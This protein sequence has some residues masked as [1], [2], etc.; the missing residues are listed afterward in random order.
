M[1]IIDISNKRFGSLTAI[2]P[3]DKRSKWD[4]V[5]WVCKCDCGTELYVPYHSLTKGNTKSCGCSRRS[6]RP[7]RRKPNRGTRLYRIWANMKNRCLNKK[8][9]YKYSRYGGRGIAICEEW[10]DFDAFCE[11]ALSSGYAEDLT[12][13]RLNNDGNYCPANCRWVPM[14]IQSKNR[15]STHW[16]TINGVTKCVKDWKTELHKSYYDIIKMEDKNDTLEGND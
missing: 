4:G 16:V 8:D 11:W 13:D 6:P 14:S 2:R 1:K 7:N 5:I 9:E 10:L 15:S 3:T 12:L